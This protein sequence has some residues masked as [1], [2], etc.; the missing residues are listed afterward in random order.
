MEKVATENVVVTAAKKLKSQRAI[1]EACGV[2]VQ[3]V[4]KWK[5][6]QVGAKYVNRFAEVTGIPRWVVRPDLYPFEKENV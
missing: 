3:A 1:A 2:S 5:K 6:K 4:S